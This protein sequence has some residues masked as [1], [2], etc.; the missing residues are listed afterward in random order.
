MDQADAQFSF[1]LQQVYKRRIV[2]VHVHVC[3][4]GEKRE[5]RA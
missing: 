5:G 1:V 3:E 4:E 2:Y